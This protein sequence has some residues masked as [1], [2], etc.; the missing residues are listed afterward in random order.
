MKDCSP[1]RAIIAIAIMVASAV[2]V[3]AQ[4]PAPPAAA[5]SGAAKVIEL[6]RLLEREPSSPIAPAI[7]RTLMRWV[8]D[9]SAPSVMICPA[10]MNP[11][12]GRK[13]TNLANLM[14]QYVLGATAYALENPDS[15]ANAVACN[16]EGVLSALRAYARLR[17]PADVPPLPITPLAELD[18][19][20]LRR[21]DGTLDAWLQT[22]V[23]GCI[24]VPAAAAA[25]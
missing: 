23:A 9:A 19:L 1:A 8:V 21:D 18:A 3:H 22:V 14:M 5:P 15:A 11:M 4:P 16:R 6:V 7:R 20:A 17:A 12:I 25:R 2:A 13:D 10:V 24:A